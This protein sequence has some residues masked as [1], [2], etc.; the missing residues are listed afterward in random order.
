[1]N[2]VI[3]PIKNL[4]LLLLTLIG[5]PAAASPPVIP[6]VPL[7]H[8]RIVVNSAADDATSRN[9]EGITLRDAIEIVDGDLPLDK[10]NAMQRG[11]VYPQPADAASRIEFNLPAG[12]AII[13]LT[14][15]LPPLLATGLTIDGTT[16]P[17]YGADESVPVGFPAMLTPPPVV[18]ITPQSGYLIARG[19]TIMADG[20]TIRGLSLYGFTDAYR[21]TAHTPSADILITD[22]LFAPE[23][24]ERRGVN[25]VGGIPK[26]T[27]IELNWL[28][29]PGRG[30]ASDETFG[31]SSFGVYVSSSD[32]AL[33]QHNFIAEHGGSGILTST[34]A[35]NLTV[36]SNT[37]DHNGVSGMPD[38]IHL[39][40]N[41]ENS[42]ISGN[43]INRNGGS[44]IYLFKTAGSVQIIKNSIVDNGFRAAQAAIYL[45]GDGH[46]VIQN[47][48]ANG[49]GPGVVVAAYPQSRSNVIQGNTFRHIGGLSIDLVTQDDTEPKALLAGD[50]T[51]GPIRSRWERLTAANRG[52]D[53]PQFMSPLFLLSP[54]DGTV[55]LIGKAPR[56][57]EVEIYRVLERGDQGPLSLPLGTTTADE[58]GRFSFTTAKLPA[59]A[60]VSATAT[61]PQDGTSEPASNSR[62]QPLP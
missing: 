27:R 54:N 29:I 55:L 7:V 2:I 20:V 25:R 60:S 46:R 11:Q 23:P 17:G 22:R 37:L 48:I 10:L 49:L 26:D 39:E 21:A 52:I 35:R 56:G 13:R 31:R 24:T 50:G 51:N 58:K 44:G 59:G 19:L 61:R 45:M 15:P 53:A 43:K 9:G 41:V 33:I 16:G 42:V 38:A 8:A 47:H 14:A 4:P 1:M 36:D 34:Q 5:L 30:A 40:G 12:G 18:S 3:N 32:S 57:S 28:G 62:I 6:T